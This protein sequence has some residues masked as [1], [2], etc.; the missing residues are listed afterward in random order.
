[1]YRSGRVLASLLVLS[2]CTVHQET[3]AVPHPTAGA[4]VAA[5]AR[6]GETAS[7]FI[8][9]NITGLVAP[10]Q[11]GRYGDS[12]RVQCTATIAAGNPLESAIESVTRTAYSDLTRGGGL[13][14]PLPGVNR[15]IAIQLDSLTLAPPILGVGTGHVD[16]EAD[17]DMRLRVSV[18]DGDGRLLLRKSLNAS[19]HG[20]IK[21][22][23]SKGCQ[24]AGDVEAAAI[25][26]AI[27]KMMQAYATQVLGASVLTPAAVE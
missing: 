21:P 17:V 24:L 6:P 5:T 4:Q 8:A 23:R 22:A 27:H 13:A 12:T 25:E 19:G 7:L 14:Q 10:F 15:H 3:F 11:Y 18:Y 26:D 9:P 16:A 1:M 2:A 20:E